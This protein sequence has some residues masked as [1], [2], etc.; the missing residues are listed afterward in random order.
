MGD[1]GATAADG[2]DACVRRRERARIGDITYG[3]N[4]TSTATFA[5]ACSLTVDQSHCLA[6]SQQHARLRQLRSRREHW[7]SSAFREGRLHGRRA[8]AGHAVRSLSRSRRRRACGST[9]SATLGGHQRREVGIEE[10]HDRQHLRPI[11][12]VPPAEGD[13]RGPSRRAR[14]SPS[15]DESARHPAGLLEVEVRMRRVPARDDPRRR[16]GTR[17]LRARAG[18]RQAP[19]AGL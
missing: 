11:D 3:A 6:V 16:G 2:K 7:R 13:A 1:A 15:A 5:A 8:E 12:G 4:D 19:A 9:E 17:A 18:A 14:C 10:Q